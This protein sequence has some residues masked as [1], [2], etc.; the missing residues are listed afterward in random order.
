MID[1]GGGGGV[2]KVAFQPSKGKGASKRI[3][4]MEWAAG[5]WW[6]RRV[7]CLV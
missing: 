5:G 7:V 3:V 6:G 4:T 1:L 2:R